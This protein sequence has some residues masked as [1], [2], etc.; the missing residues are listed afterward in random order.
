MPRV[1]ASVSRLE[2]TGYQRPNDEKR[3][4][5]EG[6]LNYATILKVSKMV[7]EESVLF[8]GATENE[9]VCKQNERSGAVKA[10]PEAA[11]E[12]QT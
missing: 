1:L 9:E 8:V 5:E 7:L 2:F 3:E 6:R 4:Q 11:P 12:A 10:R